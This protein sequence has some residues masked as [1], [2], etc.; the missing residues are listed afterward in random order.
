MLHV[1]RGDVFVRLAAVLNT[2][3]LLAHPLCGESKRMRGDI[4]G[5]ATPITYDLRSNGH[6]VRARGP[7]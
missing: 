6:R 5:H 4:H 2:L 3:N 7:R 1:V